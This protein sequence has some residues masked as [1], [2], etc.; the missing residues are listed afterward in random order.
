MLLQDTCPKSWETGAPLGWSIT[1]SCEFKL[2]W[3]S[4]C[5]SWN[6]VKKC[7]EFLNSV[8]L[9]RVECCRHV[10]PLPI[11]GSFPSIKPHAL[12]ASLHSIVVMLS[13]NRNCS[14]KV[15]CRKQPEP[16]KKQNDRSEWG[17][18][19]RPPIVL[20][21]KPVAPLQASYWRRCRNALRTRVSTCTYCKTTLK[22]V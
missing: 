9:A 13:E 15:H 5:I 10:P 11:N 1:R 4:G 12:L 20:T 19:Q 17:G 6:R 8:V 2:W 3:H 18:E 7:C 22:Y 14:L 21:F 16:S